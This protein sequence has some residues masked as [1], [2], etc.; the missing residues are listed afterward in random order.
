MKELLEHILKNITLHPE[1]V[2][3]EDREEGDTTLYTI[4]VD[5][6]DMGRVIGKSGKVI[7]A[8]RTLV[9]VAGIRTNQKARVDLK[10]SEG[11]PSEAPTKD[12][13]GTPPE[14]PATETEEEADGDD[15]SMSEKELISE[16][17]SPQDAAKDEQAT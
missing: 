7:R 17:I 2:I 10:D 9:H 4:T 1:N 11:A 5:P 3:I 14:A 15:A 6:E 8:I 13:E 12:T 16:V